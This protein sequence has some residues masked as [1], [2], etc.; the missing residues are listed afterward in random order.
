M[1]QKS[2]TIIG[3]WH[4]LFFSSFSSLRRVFDCEQLAWIWQF[5]AQLPNAD[6]RREFVK[7]EARAQAETIIVK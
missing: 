1:T 6:R 5:G 3:E 4:H 7:K 2:R